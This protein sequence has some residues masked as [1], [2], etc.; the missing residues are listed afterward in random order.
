MKKGGPKIIILF[1]APVFIIAMFLG[2]LF[3]VNEPQDIAQGLQRPIVEYQAERLKDPFQSA[4][5]GEKVGEVQKEGGASAQPPDLRVQG[6][7]WG[8]NAPQAIVNDKV[9]NAG[10]NIGEAKII[11]IDKEGVLVS[12][13]GR[14]YFF[15]SPAQKEL[16]DMQDKTEGGQNE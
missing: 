15:S 8:G 1:F 6:I 10:D 16:K 11:K 9:V 7:V 5:T 4:L 3:A 2:Y 12:S 13:G 14:Q